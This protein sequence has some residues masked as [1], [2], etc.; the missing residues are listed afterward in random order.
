MINGFLEGKHV[1]L[2]LPQEED[3]LNGTWHTW[4]NDQATTEFTSHG[5]FP[6]TIEKQRKYFQEA[7][8]DASKMV[9][10]ICDKKDDDIIGVRSLQNIDL[11]NR[12]AEQAMVIGSKKHRML[13][14]AVEATALLIEHAFERL[15]L[16]KIYGGTHEKLLEWFKLLN[17]FFGFEIEGCL[18]QEFFAHGRYWDVFRY[19]LFAETYYELKNSRNGKILGNSIMETLRSSPKCTFKIP[20]YAKGSDSTEYV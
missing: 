14:Y 11:I 12:K 3:V 18:K 5:I 13:I 10:L 6:N 2:R 19:A 17:I 8:K 9:F 7:I 15:N 16:N 20:K 1:Y 4:F